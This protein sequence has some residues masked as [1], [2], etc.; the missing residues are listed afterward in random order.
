[1]CV[2]VCVCVCA[3]Q[4]WGAGQGEGRAC[5][6]E[7]SGLEHTQLL[8]TDTHD[9]LLEGNLPRIQLDHLHTVNSTQYGCIIHVCIQV[10]YVNTCYSV[11]WR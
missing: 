1:M 10:T 5:V 4:E 6:E 11:C 7:G 2:C 9:L 3:D 8:V